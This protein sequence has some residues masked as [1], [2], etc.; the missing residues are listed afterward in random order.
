MIVV[1]DDYTF[2]KD[3]CEGAAS[4]WRGVLREGV[5]GSSEKK[6]NRGS[7]LTSVLLDTAFPV[8]FSLCSAFSLEISL[9]IFC[10]LAI[11]KDVTVHALLA[12]AC[13]S[14]LCPK[15]ILWTAHLL[16]N[17]GPVFHFT[18]LSSH[19]LQVFFFITL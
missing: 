9:S 7:K 19:L 10:L 6:S 2:G 14:S 3:E 18:Y 8:C 12:R 4:A 5:S 1:A 16:Q 11:F 13:V 15:K 17:T